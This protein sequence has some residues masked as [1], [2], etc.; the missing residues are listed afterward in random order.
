MPTWVRI[1]IYVLS[2]ILIAANLY[3]QQYQ[4][5]VLVMAM[6]MFIEIVPVVNG[7]QT[8]RIDY[9]KLA[10]AFKTNTTAPE[11]KQPEIKKTEPTVESKPAETKNKEQSKAVDLA[12]TLAK[13]DKVKA[14]GAAA[15]GY[16]VSKIQDELVDDAGSEKNEEPEEKEE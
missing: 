1:I 11:K 15:A 4:L 10:Q 9:N 5:A 8:E 7:T 6:L 16:A 12:K 2:F 3:F 14:L 13:N